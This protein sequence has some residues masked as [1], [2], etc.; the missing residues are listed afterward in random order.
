MNFTKA[1]LLTALIAALQLVIIIPIYFILGVEDFGTDSFQHF[2]GFT[3]IVA[4]FISFWFVLVLIGKL[5]VTWR[6]G[7]ERFKSL[8]LENIIYLFLIGLGLRFFIRPFFDLVEIL[9]SL[10]EIGKPYQHHQK[11]SLT[12]VYESISILVL[13]PILE[14]LF[15][16]KYLISRLSQ[17][18]SLSIAILISSIC[19]M[20]IHL[21]HY[22]NL[23]PTL[24]LGVVCAL[25]YIH[26]RNIISSIILHFFYNLVW[27]VLQIYGENY[28][29]WISELNFDIMYWV[30][31]L[32]GIMLITLGLKKL[33][34]AN[35]EL[36]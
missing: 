11:S 28:Y 31:F 36:S 25:V 21:P 6:F 14:E 2:V 23:I 29:R 3:G 16:R 4:Y 26:T 7:V 24:I 30:V 5:K 18:Y 33:N 32:F 20:L 19:F 15:F 1:I 10:N 17:K 22:S 9:P 8:K 27:F 13:P 34:T 35:K 12:L